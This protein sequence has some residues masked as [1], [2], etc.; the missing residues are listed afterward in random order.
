L[1]TDIKQNFTS[2]WGVCSVILEKD[3]LFSF[4]EIKQIVSVSGIDR[5]LLINIELSKPN[6]SIKSQLMNE[7]D[8][9]LKEFSDEDFKKFIYIVIEEILE[10]DKTLEKKFNKYLNRL[11]WQLYNGKLMSLEM[12]VQNEEWIERLWE[13][14]DKNNIPDLKWIKDEEFRIGGYW[15]G[16]PRDKEKI[17]NLTDINTDKHRHKSP[18]IDIFDKSWPNRLN[19]INKIEDTFGKNYEII[20]STNYIFFQYSNDGILIS[21]NATT[22]ETTYYQIFK[23]GIYGGSPGGGCFHYLDY[24]VI[25]D[26]ENYIAIS[27]VIDSDPDAAVT[28]H[29]FDTNTGNKINEFGYGWFLTDILFSSNSKYIISG[30]ENYITLRTVNNPK[31]IQTYSAIFDWISSIAINTNKKYIVSYASDSSKKEGVYQIWDIES[32]K[33]ITYKINLHILNLLDNNIT[34]LPKDIGNL[35]GLKYLNLSNNQLRELPEEIINLN[36]LKYLNLSYNELEVLPENIEYLTNIEYLSLKNNPNLILTQKQ[37]TWITEL[38]IKISKS[39]SSHCEIIIDDDL[40]SRTKTAH[41]SNNPIQ[42]YGNWKEGWTLDIHTLKSIPLGE[43]QFDTTYTGTGKS[44][45]E[46]KYHQNYDQISILANEVIE[47][48]KTR[49]ITPYLN[50]IIPVPPSKNRKI[51]PVERIAK[52]VAET[53]NIPFDIKYII[54]TKNTT[55]LKSIDNSA[56]REKILRDAFNIQDLRYQNKKVL[57]IDDL[58]RSGSTLKELTKILYSLGKVDNVYV[59]TLT[60]TRT[61]R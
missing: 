17:L 39:C 45:N 40:L 47:F 52:I 11:G 23:K 26:C 61:K 31:V 8:K 34:K 32:G 9:I 22:Y 46:L 50:V 51:Q 54:K 5:I 12:K 58:F 24:L 49:S 27:E 35:N 7:I 4:S 60:K 38:Q 48:L 21:L 29:I 44:L 59:I 2:V 55:E 16:I 14:A 37:K 1:Q 28:V 10:K 30:S 15:N 13:W 19:K 3:G 25:S 36:N 42:I 20:K 43:G 33:E 53:L 41:I 18:A 57:L 6:W 56:E